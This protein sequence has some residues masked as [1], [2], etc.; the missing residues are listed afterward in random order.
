[1]NLFLISNMFPSNK[2]PDYGIFVKNTTENIKKKGAIISCSSLIKGRSESF[3]IK[4]I[5]YVVYYLSIFRNY[6]FSEYDLIYT[7]FISHNSPVL[8]LLHFLFGKKK[9]LVLNLH[10]SD[11]VVYNKGVMKFFNLKLLRYVDLVIVP[12]S[13]F[14]DLVKQEFPFLK[15]SQFYVYPS[16]GINTTCF[17]PE[18]RRENKKVLNLG[19]VSRIEE[20]KGWQVFLDSLMLLKKNKVSFEAI[21]AGKGPDSINLQEYIEKLSLN[22]EV[23]YLGAVNQSRLSFLY[24]KMDVFIFPTMLKESLGLVGVEAMACGTPVIASDLAGPSTY[25]INNKNGFLFQPG[26]SNGLYK[27]ILKFNMLSVNEKDNMRKGAFKTASQYES[28]LVNEGLFRR[29]EEVLIK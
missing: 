13:Y 5:K 26:D 21:I 25:V 19:F 8:F 27:T 10:G 20:A 16:G 29:L 6:M 7:H 22:D 15:E 3:L 28:Q 4:T 14:K 11:I 23:K 9:T 24:K 18:N 1:M 12:S 17:F 2:D